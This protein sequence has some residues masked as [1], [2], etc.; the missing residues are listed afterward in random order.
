M[1]RSFIVNCSTR[2]LDPKNIWVVSAG[3]TWRQKRI[4]LRF[5]YS[6]AEFKGANLRWQLY[7]AARCARG[8]TWK[9]AFSCFHPPPA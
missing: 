7:S 9:D 8:N 4:F 5:G 6:Q 2:L 3:P 1:E